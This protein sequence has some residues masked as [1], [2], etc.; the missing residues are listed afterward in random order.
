MDP[1]NPTRIFNIWTNCPGYFIVDKEGFKS[2]GYY[3]RGVVKV[4][5]DNNNLSLYCDER[6]YEDLNFGYGEFNKAFKEGVIENIDIKWQENG[7]ESTPKINQLVNKG[8]AEMH[9]MLPLTDNSTLMADNNSKIVISTDN[10]DTV[11]NAIVKNDSIIRGRLFGYSS[12]KQINSLI[13]GSGH[14]GS[15]IGRVNVSSKNDDNTF[16]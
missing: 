13:L 10:P 15:F 7:C 16:E 14:I 9:I 2:V 5:N 8:G 6:A 1:Q 11:C 12:I 4:E 3:N